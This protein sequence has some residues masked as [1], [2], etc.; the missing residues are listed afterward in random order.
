MGPVSSSN[1]LIY[2]IS[3]GCRQ[4]DMLPCAHSNTGRIYPSLNGVWY[5]AKP[6][7]ST[8]MNSEFSAWAPPEDSKLK[9]AGILWVGSTC[10]QL[11]I[12]PILQKYKKTTLSTESAR[13]SW[14]FGRG[15]R[16][17]VNCARPWHSPR[18]FYWPLRESPRFIPRCHA[19]KWKGST[20]HTSS[21]QR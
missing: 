11:F 8:H 17:H 15:C 10:W 5:C 14:M 12:C 2:L 21:V 1:L 7:P 6:Q 18:L 16:L 19:W 3:T 13:L 9:Q 4:S 20:T